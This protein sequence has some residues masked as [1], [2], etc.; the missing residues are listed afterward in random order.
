M[1]KEHPQ[2]SDNNHVEDS[3]VSYRGIGKQYVTVQGHERG[4]M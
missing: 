3:D 2:M 1:E 4:R